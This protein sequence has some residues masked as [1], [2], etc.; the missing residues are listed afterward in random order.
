M[1]ES[2]GIP[3]CCRSVFTMFVLGKTASF[4]EK[5]A[6][7]ALIFVTFLD[8]V[9]LHQAS[10]CN[11]A[12]RQLIP[13]N[14]AENDLKDLLQAAA[15][16]TG[17]HEFSDLLGTHMYYW[18]TKNELPGFKGVERDAKAILIAL[19]GA[20]TPSA[21]GETWMREAKVLS[22]YGISVISLDYPF[23]RHG[24]RS[25]YWNNASFFFKKLYALVKEYRKSGK[26]VF[27]V[28][29]SFGGTIIR[30]MLHHSPRIVSG[31]GLFSP[32]GWVSPG[33]QA[34]WLA[35]SLNIDQQLY[36]AERPLEVGVDWLEGIERQ[37]RSN[38]GALTPAEVPVLIIAGDQDPLSTPELIKDLSEQMP[39]S[40][41][42]IFKG[43][44]HLIFE[45]PG[46]SDK[47]LRERIVHQIERA[48]GQ[49]LK[50]GEETIDRR[51]VLLILHGKSSLFS[52]WLK[53]AGLNLGAITRDE[54]AANGAYQQWHDWLGDKLVRASWVRINELQ[55][56]GRFGE[57]LK[58]DSERLVPRFPSVNKL[59][60][61]WSGLRFNDDGVLS[62]GWQFMDKPIRLPDWKDIVEKGWNGDS[63]QQGRA[64]TRHF[65]PADTE[66]LINFLL[67]SD[68][69]SAQNGA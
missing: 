11:K 9:S 39:G 53:K 66:N 29:H 58:S 36:P 28:G 47:L 48:T 31:A 34:H 7:Y 50:K 38:R 49:K 24:P 37:L 2:V 16:N 61:E 59:C 4:T 40:Q 3:N 1:V 42:E 20:G 18:P 52:V 64:G 55:K 46:T 60:R 43:S 44:G 25:A 33:L 23:H 68:M 32:G 22:T 56:T 26:A 13:F 57:Y 14:L 17:V 27:I 35:D 45:H 15:S 63:E 5:V 19:G 51:T 65:G 69:H 12:Y 30:D 21:S 54:R 10:G 67:E 41:Y 6:R 62:H 8:L